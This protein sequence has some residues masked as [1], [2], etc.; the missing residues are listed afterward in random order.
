MTRNLDI[1]ICFF[2]PE[3][4]VLEKELISV[5]KPVLN[6]TGWKNPERE[7]IKRLRKVCADEARAS[8]RRASVL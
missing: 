8:I 6:L 2:A 4:L 1:G 3:D 7:E 5:L